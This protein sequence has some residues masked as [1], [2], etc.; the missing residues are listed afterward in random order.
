MLPIQGSEEQKRIY[1]RHVLPPTADDV[2]LL[3]P[4]ARPDAGP[5]VRRKLILIIDLDSFEGWAYLVTFL[6]LSSIGACSTVNLI[7]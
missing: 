3:S 4:L 1:E 5:R 2:P 6:M 7:T